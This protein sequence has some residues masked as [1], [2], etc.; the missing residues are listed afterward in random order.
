MD[1][2]PKQLQ[3]IGE[4]VHRVNVWEGAVRSGKT[5]SSI[6]RF[7]AAIPGAAREGELVITGRNLDSI[8]RNFFA[9]I[10]NVPDLAWLLPHI[11][12]RQ[13]AS[14][15]KILGRRVNII[16][17]NDNRAEG[18]LRGMT[19]ALV[20]VDEI[21]VLPENFFKQM[22]ARMSAPGA[23]MFG[24]TN[25]DGPRHWL[26]TGYLDRIGADLDNWARWRF[27]LDDNPTLTDEYKQALKSEYTGL[28]YDRFIRG[29]WVAAEGAIFD[30]FVA[31]HYPHGNLVN[32]EQLH[33]DSV[34]AAGIDQGSTNPTAA[35]TLALAT[36]DEQPRLVLTDEW[37][38][39]GA[40]TT[41]RMTSAEQAERITAWLRSESHTGGSTPTPPRYIYADPAAADFREEMR[42][43][44]IT[45]YRADNDVV[46]GIQQMG[47]LFARQQLLV[48]TSCAGLLDEL[49]GYVWDAKATAEGRDRPVK[50]DDHSIDAAR[51][52][53]MSS[54]H[55]WR[56]YVKEEPHA[57]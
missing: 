46:A 25:P 5:I 49:P 41:A 3:A 42:R 27:T 51:Y 23:Q 7:M 36:I 48:A 8:Y 18:K 32:L 44:G 24:T 19:V 47:S 52:A 29:L 13:G 31:Q 10:E 57:A 30:T 50:A 38:Y 14:S 37:R 55:K 16:G 15:A 40:A 54:R 43:Q 11:S 22:L 17:A 33:I 34:L 56:R 1:F 21:T 20:Y 39:N 9:P 35:L 12:Y 28:W 45:T 26:K 53:I 4:S 6:V 2:S